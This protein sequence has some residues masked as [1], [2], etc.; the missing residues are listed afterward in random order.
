MKKIILTKGKFALVDDEDFEW[1]NKFSWH[2]SDNGYAVGR[3]SKTSGKKCIWMHREIL[4]T[5]IGMDTD[6]IDMNKL[7]NQRSNLRICSRSQNMMNTK[8]QQNNTTGFRGVRILRG[9]SFQSYININKR[10]IHLGT[11]PDLISAA[12]AYDAK[13]KELFGEFA[14]LNL[15]K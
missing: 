7:N 12:K 9:K 3:T 10:R 13:S 5:P 1:L 14:Y 6:H 4:G 11:F 2:Y 15:R 8:R